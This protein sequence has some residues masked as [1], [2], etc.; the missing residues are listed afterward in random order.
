LTNAQSSIIGRPTLF[1][2]KQS[3]HFI[4]YT[5][6]DDT[7]GGLYGHVSFYF[8]SF[9]SN[10]AKDMVKL[11]KIYQHVFP[12]FGKTL[13]S[14]QEIKFTRGILREEAN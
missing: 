11:K 9:D 7:V 12:Y 5:G 2:F 13:N 3:F 10:A 14:V 6:E 1:K 4:L 8:N